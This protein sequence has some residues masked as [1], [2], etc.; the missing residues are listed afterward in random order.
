MGREENIRLSMAHLTPTK[1]TGTWG[2]LLRPLNADE[3][4]DCGWMRTEAAALAAARV[5]GIYSHGSASAGK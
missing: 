1:I 4:M 2:A 5:D 3:T